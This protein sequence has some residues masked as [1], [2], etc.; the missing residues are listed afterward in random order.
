MNEKVLF[1]FRA[2]QTEDGCQY[3][4]RH[5]DRVFIMRPPETMPR[6]RRVVARRKNS[7]KPP[8]TSPMARRRVRHTLDTLENLYA[9]LYPAQQAPAEDGQADL[10]EPG[11]DLP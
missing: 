10:P 8:Q 4:M 9:D 3:K 6:C 11:E 5:G 2:I 1:E 7:R